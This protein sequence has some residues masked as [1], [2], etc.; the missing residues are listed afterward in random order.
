MIFY[1]ERGARD[2]A[3]LER[4]ERTRC[5]RATCRTA[6]RKFM[7]DLAGKGGGSMKIRRVSERRGRRAGR[8]CIWTAF[9]VQKGTVKEKARVKAPD[10]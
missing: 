4:R 8:T 1:R 9:G 2:L 7:R 10:S 6:K 5:G 3:L